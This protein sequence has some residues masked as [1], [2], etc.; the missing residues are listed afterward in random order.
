[1]VIGSDTTIG[2]GRPE[3]E[4]TNSA[5]SANETALDPNSAGCCADK[6]QDAVSPE[7]DLTQRRAAAQVDAKGKYEPCLSEHGIPSDVL[8]KLL[9]GDDIV[10]LVE[11]KVGGGL[12]YRFIKRAFDLVSCGCALIVLAIPMVVIAAKIKLESPGPVI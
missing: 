2:G 8:A 12:G 11:P 7:L 1:M 9:P 6:H 5:F 3:M 4:S 10:E